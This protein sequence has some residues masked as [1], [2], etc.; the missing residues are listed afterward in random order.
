MSNRIETGRLVWNKARLTVGD[1]PTRDVRFW[2]DGTTFQAEDPSSGAPVGTLTI[3]VDSDGYRTVE[4]VDGKTFNMTGE[5]G[6][7]W[8]VHA[9]GCGC[10]GG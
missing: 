8:L 4:R 1:G 10:S 7:V 9:V 6:T 5:D 2:G 3:A